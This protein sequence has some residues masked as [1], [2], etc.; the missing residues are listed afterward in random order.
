M[1]IPKLFPRYMR[2]P[3][4][5]PDQAPAVADS[6]ELAASVDYAAMLSQAASV[7]APSG[8]PSSAFVSAPVVPVS[9]SASVVVPAAAIPPPI[10]SVA[11]MAAA[12]A[13][14]LT[15]ST[16]PAPAP[17]GFITP[18]ISA[19]PVLPEQPPIIHDSSPWEMEGETGL[20]TFILWVLLLSMPVIMFM[21]LLVDLFR[22]FRDDDDSF[23][24]LRELFSRGDDMPSFPEPKLKVPVALPVDDDNGNN[25]SN[26]DPE[27]GLFVTNV[28]A[29]S[30]GHGKDAGAG[31]DHGGGSGSESGKV[32]GKEIDATPSTTASADFAT[33]S[34][35]A[36]TAAAT[37]NRGSSPFLQQ[38]PMLV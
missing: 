2:V 38:S 33:F 11:A 18:S 36:T 30:H 22:K 9:A 26:V 1:R 10:A 19:V 21:L 15:Q 32:K 34:S 14:A 7:L 28:P 29:P 12:I 37:A 6:A 24:R 27:K 25:G 13:V 4:S 3:D 8:A 17:A 31:H 5:E 20:E 23:V 35:S 16:A